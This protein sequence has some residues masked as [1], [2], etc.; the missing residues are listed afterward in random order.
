[1]KEI[2]RN[3]KFFDNDGQLD[4]FCMRYPLTLFLQEHN[5]LDESIFDTSCW[6]HPTVLYNNS[7][8]EFKQRK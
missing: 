5:S 8:G 6:H 7:C 3:C 2:C 1:M 4:G